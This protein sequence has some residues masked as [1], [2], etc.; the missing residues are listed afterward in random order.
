[1]AT[2]INHNTSGFATFCCGGCSWSMNATSTPWRLFEGIEC[3]NYLFWNG[4]FISCGF[5]HI[6][7]Q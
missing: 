7:F 3:N 5:C 2:Y 6:V 1:M 4:Q